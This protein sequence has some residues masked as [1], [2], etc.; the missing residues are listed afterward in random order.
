MYV[1]IYICIYIYIYVCIYTDIYIQAY[2]YRYIYTSLA[3]A[4]TGRIV[5]PIAAAA[6]AVAPSTARVA[7]RAADRRP[8]LPG[9]DD[10]P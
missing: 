1:C 4:H 10:L 7:Q 8:C 2:I 5:R 6:V 3:P 9:T